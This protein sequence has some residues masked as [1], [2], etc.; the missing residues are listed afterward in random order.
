M[1]RL[2]GGLILAS[3]VRLGWAQE[4]RIP[5]NDGWSFSQAGKGEW[6][7]AE[8]P[9]VVQTDLLRNGLIPDFMRGSN[10]D[11]VQ[12]IENEDWVY[13][14][15]LFVTDT[16]LR[17]GH[18]DL[19]FKGLDTFAEV[20]VNDSLLGRAD[21]MFR[22]WEWPVRALLRKGENEL[23]LIFRSPIKEGAKLRE[24]YGIQ[25]PHD[26]DPSGVSPY[27]RKAAYQFGWDFCP[28]LVTSGIWKEVELRGWSVGRIIGLDMGN[29]PLGD[30]LHLSIR[31]VL[32]EL[33]F[34]GGAVRFRLDDST[35]AESP[36]GNVDGTGFAGY[37]GTIAHPGKW[38]P[39]NLGPQDLHVIAV[40]LL[41]KNGTIVSRMAE[42]VGFREVNL[43]QDVDSI[44]NSFKVRMNGNDIL[45]KGC[46]M[47][48][49]SM[50]PIGD[51]PWLELVVQMQ[52]AGMNM[53]RVWSGGVYPPD[54]FYT[55][56]DTAGIMVWQDLM[57]ANMV[58]GS[59]EFKWNLLAEADET[60][61]LIRDHPCSTIMCGDN[62]L[63]VAWKNWGWQDRYDLHGVDSSKVI[64]AYA[65]LHRSLSIGPTGQ[66]FPYTPT[67]P[68]S[69]WGNAKG[70][71][72]GDL[73]YWGVWH[74]D[75]TFSSFKNNVGRFMSEWG[76]QSY[77]DS[78]TLANYI[79][80]DSLYMGSPAVARLQR[81][82][83][84]D[85]PIWEAIER[86]LGEERPTTLGGFIEA[87]Q[88]AQAKAYGMAIEAHMAAR[89]HCMGT[90]L[91]QLNDCWPGPSWSIIDYE[92]R[93]K[94]A[95][96]VVKNLFKSTE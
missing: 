74:G 71:T 46:N 63:M 16:L 75:S 17:H 93:P 1:K 62:E 7:P 12:W 77:P 51:D 69:N 39:R 66:H 38:W 2:L 67:S 24:A 35:L 45:A 22:T 95:Y 41:D 40:E 21:N 44:G 78:A 52:V 13:K 82:Y 60:F 20:Y 70:L 33:A 42:R 80:P 29:E 28:R 59:D 53:V 9:G 27:I 94:P 6:Y 65:E 90:L 96:E 4:V 48:P 8:V 79:D 56:C 18:L 25:L 87:S 88:R 81:S 50:V 54:A 58:P 57:L 68:L 91:W 47:V 15:T 32:S 10:I 92:G 83:K 37:A 86:E 5:M 31:A 61:A 55:A 64:S 30:S 76:F 73:H 11:S 3:F 26:N 85:R 23:K 72:E 19:V 49:P 34:D 43:L 14:R 89:P 84:T 36:I